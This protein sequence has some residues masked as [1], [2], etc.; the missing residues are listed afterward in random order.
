ME[1]TKKE[2]KWFIERVGKRIYRTNNRCNCEICVTAYRK[3]IV[4]LD[5]VHAMYLFDMQNEMNLFYE[6]NPE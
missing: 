2:Q 3:G 1:A 4:I 6:E 5:R